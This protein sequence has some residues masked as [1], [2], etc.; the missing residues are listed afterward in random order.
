M[1]EGARE[2]EACQWQQEGRA[3]HAGVGLTGMETVGWTDA[4]SLTF[5]VG[6]TGHQGA[7]E[8][9]AQGPI[10]T[11]FHLIVAVGVQVSELHGWHLAVKQVGF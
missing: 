4:S 2:N 8:A 6:A 9:L 1:L 11:H 7:V 5:L 10:G 3:R